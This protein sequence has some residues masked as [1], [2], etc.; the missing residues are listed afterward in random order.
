MKNKLLL[1]LSVFFIFSFIDVMAQKQFKELTSVDGMDVLYMWQTKK[2]SKPGEVTILKLKFRNNNDYRV[3]MNFTVDFYYK[4]IR[5]ASSEEQS[6][7]V[8][9]DKVAVLNVKKLGF[10]KGSFTNEQIMSEDFILELSDVSV[11]KS[12]NCKTMKKK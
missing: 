9:S 10:D 4:A 6:V 8:M 2:K 5:K 3:Q 7:C 11:K 12:P 1:F